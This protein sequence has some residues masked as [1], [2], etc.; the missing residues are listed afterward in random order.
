M[1]PRWVKRAEERFQAATWRDS[2]AEISPVEW[3]HL[4]LDK[5]YYTYR[6]LKDKFAGQMKP[7]EIEA[8]WRREMKPHWVVQLE[9]SED[10][11]DDADEGSESGDGSREDTGDRAT[12]ADESLSLSAI[13][14]PPEKLAG[15]LLLASEDSFIARCRDTITQVRAGLRETD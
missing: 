3:R 5:A 2:G 9:D 8:L 4:P 10:D 1:K 13:V 11:E 7:E 14:T 15:D 12:G 6:L